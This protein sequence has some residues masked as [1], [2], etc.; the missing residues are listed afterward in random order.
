M[1]VKFAETLYAV[2]ILTYGLSICD[3]FFLLRIGR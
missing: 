3:R 2:N 1:P